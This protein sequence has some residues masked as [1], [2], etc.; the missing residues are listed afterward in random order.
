M[1]HAAIPLLHDTHI[2]AHTRAR[3]RIHIFRGIPFY[4]CTFGDMPAL[5][6]LQ[7]LSNIVSAVINREG[8][9]LVS[10]PPENI[11]L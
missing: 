6:R 5:S 1:P 3:A 7:Y 4:V 11:S 10:Y 2:H 8:V 9:R